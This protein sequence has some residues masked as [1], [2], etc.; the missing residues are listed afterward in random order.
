[1]SV[2]VQHV[3]ACKVKPPITD[4]NSFVENSALAAVREVFFNNNR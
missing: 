1:M 2:V 4:K 3:V